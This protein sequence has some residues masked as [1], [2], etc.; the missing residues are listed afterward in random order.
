MTELE[1]KKFVRENYNNM[2]TEEIGKVIGKSGNAVRKMAFVMG[3]TKRETTYKSKKDEIFVDMKLDN[4]DNY[5]ISNYGT[6]RNKKRNCI[7]KWGY[8]KDGYPTIK[9]RKNDG[10]RIVGRV[11]RYVAKY[12]VPNPENLKQVNHIDGNKTNAYFKNLE[13]CNNSDNQKHAYETGLRAR[14]KGIKKVK[15]SKEQIISICVE[16]EKQEKST[17][18]IADFL[19]LPRSLVKDIKTRKTHKKISNNYKF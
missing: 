4:F 2:T 16:L 11:H 8:T 7:I 14:R 1:K 10:T 12:F 17:Y 5:T 13:W 9:L 15:Y 19:K 6:F 18:E 3:I